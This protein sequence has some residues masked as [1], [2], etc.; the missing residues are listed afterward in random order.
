MNI[1]YSN[2]TIPPER[3]KADIEKLLK[4]HGITDMQWTNYKGDTTLRFLWQVTVKGVQKEI[5]FQFTPPRI[6]AQ[7]RIWS[8]SDQRTIKATV[9]LEATSYRL[10]WWYLKAKLEVVQYGLESLEKEFLSHAVV[11][12][13]NGKV[14]TVGESVESVFEAVR[15]PAL[16]YQPERTQVQDEKVVDI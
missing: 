15:S 8:Q 11:S 10:M 13:P 7:K 2:T 14:T 5:M 3:S 9:Q 1:P 16:T 4:E 12:L 6:E